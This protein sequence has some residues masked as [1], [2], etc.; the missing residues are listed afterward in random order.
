[1]SRKAV[2]RRRVPPAVSVGVVGVLGLAA[3]VIAL[4]LLARPSVIITKPTP[5]LPPGSYPTAPVAA[6]EPAPP[7][8]A[9]GWVNR[10]P[11][12]AADR[13]L[14]VLDVWTGWCP[15]CRE[16]APALVAAH[17]KFGPR[18]VE[19]VS[20]TDMPRPR[21]EE[22]VTGFGVHWPCGYGATL[23]A[24]AQFGAFEAK[25]RRRPA[26]APPESSSAV[27]PT[28]FL[29]AP[30]GRVVWNDGQNRLRHQD[31]NEWSADLEAAIEQHL[32]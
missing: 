17:R 6:G 12:D 24:L 18:G 4:A 9:E 7:I 28:V 14:V 3:V 20:V 26:D 19:F 21:V 13:K 27:S 10:P 25:P 15:V 30:D 31:P 2:W 11:A 1:M 29:I 16:T 5:L 8:S 22:F 32:R 23:A